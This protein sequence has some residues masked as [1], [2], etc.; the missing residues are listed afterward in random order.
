MKNILITFA[1]AVLTGCVSTNYSTF[2]G[3]GVIEGTGGTKK[4]VEGVDIWDNGSPPRKYKIIGIIDDDRPDSLISRSM[5]NKALVKKAK[6]AGGDAIIMVES[7]SEVVGSTNS[8]SAQIYGDNINY[9][10]SSTAVR[11]KTTKVAVIKYV[12]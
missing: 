6:E 4:T 11:R 7:K 3:G 2:E 9:Q 5:Q 10:G 8:G 1:A 12:D